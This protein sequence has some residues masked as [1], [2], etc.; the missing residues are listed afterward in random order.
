MSKSKKNVIDPE[1]IIEEYG[2]D[3]ARWFML[4][5]SPPERDINWSL[6]GINGAWR[7]TQ[8]FWRV[9]RDC[10]VI[11]DVSID[12]KPKKFNAE[13]INFRKKIHK[14]LKLITDGI[15]SFQMN[16]AVAKIHELTSEI[17]NFSIKDDDSKWAKREALNILIRVTEPMMPHITEECWALIG[18]SRSIIESPWPKYEE[19]LLVS[20]EVIIIIQINGKKRGEITLP[21]ESNEN[22]VYNESIKLDNIKKFILPDTIIKK[23]IYISNRILNI[24]I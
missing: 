2:A 14:N 10:K 3:T 16:V 22:D 20:D 23:K 11:F 7:F 4:S 15:N 6:S 19:S 12:K 18:N 5:D 21:N 9:V 8:K 13:T 1:N 17:S 24:V